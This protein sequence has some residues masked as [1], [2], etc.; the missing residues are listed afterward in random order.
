MAQ[1]LLYS[2]TPRSLQSIA[3]ATRPIGTEPEQYESRLLQANASHPNLNS[4]VTPFRPTILTE[5]DN[6][7]VT[8]LHRIQACPA[9]NQAV[10]ANLSLHAGGAATMGLA[11][12][13]WET[14]IPDAIGDMNTF[15]GNGIGAAVAKSNP[16]LAAI[17]EYDHAVKNY[18]D[19]LN[20]RAAPRTLRGAKAHMERAFEAMNRQFNRAALPYL[21]NAEYKMRQTTTVTGKPVWESIPVRDNADVIKLEKLT[22]VGRI[23]GPGII[24]IDGYLRANKV[25]HMRKENNPAWK[26]EAFIQGGAFAA[27]IIVGAAIGTVVTLTPGGLIIAFIAGGVAGVTLDRIAQ[28]GFGRLHDLMF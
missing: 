20:H 13:L 16:V 24:A 5:G 2:K 15:G 6:A 23:A 25:H 17:G 1:A 22:K 7:R 21:N 4:T 18:E 14:K 9:E 8:N 27:G 10:L 11:S 3:H 19:L 26:R 12:F 28:S